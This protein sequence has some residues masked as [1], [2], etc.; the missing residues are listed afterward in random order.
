MGL[1]SLANFGLTII[2]AVLLTVMG[3][4]KAVGFRAADRRGDLLYFLVPF[5][6][7]FLN[8]IPGIQVSSWRYLLEVFV[9][10]LMV[11]FVE[12]SVFRGLMLNVLK[13]RGLW[14]AAIITTLLFGFTHAL[15]I[16]YAMAMGF[17]AL[18]LRK[19]ILWPLVLTHW[20]LI[21]SP[22]S[23]RPGSRT[24]RRGMC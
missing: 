20:L 1:Y 17:A 8:F 13:T 21:S 19:G 14:K 5:I 24:R 10:T 9:I 23:S 12:E 3:W 6:P 4:W 22:S 16:C 18:V 15:Q 7:M 11:G 2:V